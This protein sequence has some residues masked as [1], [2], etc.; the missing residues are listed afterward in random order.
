M[1][2]QARKLQARQPGVRLWTMRAEAA[3]RDK[4]PSE[5]FDVRLRTGE[6]GNQMDVGRIS[7]SP[8]TCVDT[9]GS[10]YGGGGPG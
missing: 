6:G 5:S 9:V 7:A 3:D 4:R 1:S 8:P 2:R 10:S